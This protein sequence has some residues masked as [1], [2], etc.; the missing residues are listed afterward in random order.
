MFQD[1]PEKVGIDFDSREI[2]RDDFVLAYKD[3]TVLCRFDGDSRIIFPCIEDFKEKPETVFAFS[4][5]GKRYFLSLSD[6]SEIE[7]FGYEDINL[8]KNSYMD[9]NLYAGITGFHYYAFH[10]ENKFCGKCG[11]KLVHDPKKRCMFCTRC[12]NEIFSKISP[13]VIVG[14]IDDETDSIVLTK[15]AQGKYRKYA[16]VAGFAEMGESIEDAARREVMEETGLEITDLKYYKSQPW[17]FAQNL[18][19]GFFAKVKNSR[20]IHMDEE[21]LSEALWVKRKDISAQPD[22]LSLTNEMMWKFKNGEV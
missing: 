13:A 16:L 19:F 11:G 4:A 3:R 14:I 17:G 20:E 7:N 1:I 22:S 15:Y 18:L 5:D 21:E 9:T 6:N 2:D 8:L 12:K 10:A